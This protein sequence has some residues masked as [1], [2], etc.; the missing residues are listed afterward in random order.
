M[1]PPDDETPPIVP[2]SEGKDGFAT[3]LQVRR[4]Q[5]GVLTRCC[6][7]ASSIAYLHASLRLS[8]GQF[9]FTA[10]LSHLPVG[11]FAFIAVLRRLPLCS[12]ISISGLP[13]H[14]S[15]SLAVDS[16]QC[17]A[18]IR[19]TQHVVCMGSPWRRGSPEWSCAS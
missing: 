9:V 13:A 10:G 19:L 2:N 11:L 6:R 18:A 3:A 4:T 17:V 15:L 16:C 7:V 5:R 8:A 1:A 14:A 12:Q